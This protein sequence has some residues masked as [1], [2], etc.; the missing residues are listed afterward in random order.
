MTRGIRVAAAGL[1]L[2]VVGACTPRVEQGARAQ[3][4]AGGAQA[5]VGPDNGTFAFPGNDEGNVL[6]APGG[7]SIAR[8]TAS[9]TFS[10]WSAV[11]T[12]PFGR[13]QA[14]GAAWNGRLYVVGGSGLREIVTAAIHDDGTLG[15]FSQATPLPENRAS[16]GAAAWNGFL[17]VAGGRLDSGSGTSAVTAYK[18]K[19]DGTLGA[20]TSVTAMP[21]AS[22]GMGVVAAGGYLYTVAGRTPGNTYRTNVRYAPINADGSLG[23][24]QET[25]PIIGGGSSDNTAT[26]FNGRIYYHAVQTPTA[27]TAVQSAPLGADGKVG[28]WRGES[29]P[30]FTGFGITLQAAGGVMALLGGD[31]FVYSAQIGEGGVLSP[32]VKSASLASRSYAASAVWNDRLYVASG[33]SGTPSADVQSAAIG[34]PPTVWTQQNASGLKGNRGAVTAYNGYAYMIGGAAQSMGIR[35]VVYAALNPDGSVA[36]SGWQSAADLTWNST[37]GALVA[38]NGRLYLFGFDKTV[39]VSS[40]G[41]GGAPGAWTASPVG[42]PGV[43]AGAAAVIVGDYLILAGGYDDTNNLTAT[44]YIFSID[45]ATGALSIAGTGALPRAVTNHNL[46]SDG[47]RVYL[48]G[49]QG[50]SGNSTEVN[51]AV[52]DTATG[53][54]GAWSVV[55]N[56]PES[57]YAAGVAVHAGTLVVVGGAYNSGPNNAFSSSDVLTARLDAA[58]GAVGPW[59]KS[60][61][62]WAARQY[63]AL[64]SSG[65]SL[66][67]IT[68]LGITASSQTDLLDVW[69]AQ[70]VVAGV[71]G[72]FA[73]NTGVPASSGRSAAAA[74]S[75]GSRV[76][77]TGGSG[78]AATGASALGTVASFPI[79]ADGSLGAAASEPPLVTAR[80]SHTALAANGFLYVAGGID[81]T[82]YYNS[83]E[84]AAVRPTGLAAFQATTPFS[85]GRYRHGM[86][87]A[88]GFLYVYGGA[89][90]TGLKGDVQFAP[91]GGDGAV[92]A[93][94]NTTQLS[95][96]RST[97][98]AVAY[99]GYLYA[100]GGALAGGTTTSVEYAP[101]LPSGAVGG[102]RGGSSLHAT[103]PN[104]PLLAFGQNGVLYVAD[105]TGVQSAI[106]HADGSLGDWQITSTGYGPRTSEAAALGP[107]ALYLLG[108]SAPGGTLLSDIQLAPLYQP[109]QRAAYSRLF[110]L[111]AVQ[112]S[113]DTLTVSGSALPGRVT[114]D[115]ATA[116][117]D[118]KFTTAF[119]G[120]LATLGTPLTLGGTGGVAGV[121][122][123]QARLLLDDTQAP[124]DGA[125]RDVTGLVVGYTPGPT[126]LVFQAQPLTITAGVCATGTLSLLDASG[127]PAKT[128]TA[129]PVTLAT[130]SPIPQ[131][132]LFAGSACTGSPSAS[133]AFAPGT[134]AVPFSVLVT[135]T[136]TGDVVFTAT[137]SGLPAVTQTEKLVA[138]PPHH[139]TFTAQPA[140]AVAGLSFPTA[141]A[142]ALLDL[143]GNQVGDA[144]GVALALAAGSPAGT[145]GGDLARSITTG[146]ATFTNLSLDK[147]GTGFLLGVKLVSQPSITAVSSPFNVTAPP[148]PAQLVFDAPA[149]ATVT[150]G[151]CT[152]FTLALRDTGGKATAATSPLTISVAT[153]G[154]PAQVFASCGG[155][156]TT[157]LSFPVAATTLSFGVRTSGVGTG[158]LTLTATAAALPAAGQTA[159]QAQT[160]VAGAPDHLAF[161]TQPGDSAAG[162]LLSVSPVVTVYDGVGN[163]A[164]GYGNQVIAALA[165]GSPAG[166][167][168]G[169]TSVFASAGVATFS[170][171]KVDT[172]GAGY[173]LTAG[174]PSPSTVALV[175]S[176]P[177]TV[178]PPPFALEFGPLP[179]S[180]IIGECR[181][182]VEVRLVD[183]GRQPVKAATTVP[184][185]LT[186]VGPDTARLS[187]SIDE[188][189][190][191]AGGGQIPAGASK[192]QVWLRAPSS[193]RYTLG[194]SSGTL[195]AAG[196]TLDVDAPVAVAP[197][198]NGWG[199]ASSGGGEGGLVALLGG[200]FTLGRT[201]RRRRPSACTRKRAAWW[202]AALLALLS[203][204]LPALALPE[205]APP[206]APSKTANEEAKA[207][208]VEGQSEYDLGHFKE[209]LVFFEKAY[210]KKAVPALLYN[211]AQCHRMLG[212]LKA[213]RATYRSFLTN[214]PD[215][216]V[217]PAA[218]EKLAE[219]EAALSAQF[220]VQSSLPTGI[221]SPDKPTEKP[222]A[223]PPK[224]IVVEQP[225]LTPPPAPA[226][227]PPAP[228]VTAPAA[229][230]PAPKQ[231]P[232]AQAETAK[233]PP[234][235][236]DGQRSLGPNVYF[237]GVSDPKNK[238]VGLEAAL[239]L[240]LSDTLSL[241]A[242]AAI[243]EHLGLRVAAFFRLTE[244]GSL[245]LW[246]GPRLLVTPGGDGPSV[247]GGAQLRAELQVTPFLDVVGAAALEAYKTPAGTTV[248]PLL[249]AGLQTRF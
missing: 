131:G 116:G 65:N 165:A 57:R 224:I 193:G 17:Y 84:V 195:A 212:D 82:K 234:A 59:V 102:W 36:G 179:T 76:F 115:V 197:H 203:L 177:F 31:N 149:P 67:L 80:A 77:L 62:P 25:T 167:L 148:P 86:A 98:G 175:T 35:N 101:L 139:L 129:L 37:F 44:L 108:G 124:F 209:A 104:G 244:Q 123:V 119:R 247:G 213:A 112:N 225:A 113:A 13:G 90:G 210:K 71:V 144:G 111:G 142:V 5:L 23:G 192:L 21:D 207:L 216:P 154:V 33:G 233:R 199:C 93:W 19:A 249:T 134:D 96:P 72:P 232:P 73:A 150:A 153:T 66:V 163:V 83:V 63:G 34:G 174:L 138:G 27:A 183:V 42:L 50:P 91:L 226:P 118:G 181:G 156:A 152:S 55:S 87:S 51:A 12:L 190:G 202:P 122:W 105:G 103:D 125:A 95:A 56:L 58:S 32:W 176:A 29:T 41:A 60:T 47:S 48:L 2:A 208:F 162:A 69:S 228:L 52:L 218:R 61:A 49:G 6:F 204:S 147:A 239:L 184:V 128:T 243:G 53:R 214:A 11:G 229:P 15:S 158:T 28:D 94:T 155:T 54:L 236:A 180:V 220:K 219:V 245:R 173:K 235:L 89:D 74:A 46:V 238:E 186:G 145:L 222:A 40:I 189:C 99:G 143:V 92:G 75:T 248:A 185:T 141:P 68:G 9:G 88:G 79:N 215:S 133:Y 14:T 43:L 132:A 78:D 107:S 120:A 164:T 4:A 159:S 170:G 126:Q 171:L 1:L 7:G 161:T 18:I 85:G 16:P 172:G 10:S 187:W 70:G 130:A 121:R 45:R 240:S 246:A 237:G 24:W 109:P 100:L 160:V 20:A 230:A 206:A 8:G 188:G 136:G 200:L 182:P 221:E 137:V 157:T 39:Y 106:V 242:G 191:L 22:F 166:S 205:A 38:Y 178:T 223:P 227:A 201:L 196:A 127:A 211:V 135:T 169:T 241:L 217:A 26:V 64:V 198:L 81:A 146:T 151:A 110:D 30:P 114:V 140:D 117:A 168:T 194:A 97:F 231:P 3:G